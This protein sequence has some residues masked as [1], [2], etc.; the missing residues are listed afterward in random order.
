MRREFR[1]GTDWAQPEEVQTR[2]P[3]GVRALPHLGSVAGSQ[4]LL[5]RPWERGGS[6]GGRAG[7][8]G[9]AAT[10]RKA[11]E[12]QPGARSREGAGWVLRGVP[13]LSASGPGTLAEPGRLPA[14]SP[15]SSALS[16]PRAG[17]PSLQGALQPTPRTPHRLWEGLSGSSLPVLP[18]S[19]R[20]GADQCPCPL[21]PL[22][23]DNPRGSPHLP[24]ASSQGTAN[25]TPT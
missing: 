5:R 18:T 17:S 24:S 4:M 3:G 8:R 14:D 20:E 12:G 13:G 22:P 10:G 16:P 9:A 11:A 6:L 25:C 21:G 1:R 2:T 19:P 23:P 15:P 7:A